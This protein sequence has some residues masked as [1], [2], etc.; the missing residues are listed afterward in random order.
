MSIYYNSEMVR[1]L[2]RERIQEAEAAGLASRVECAAR[3]ARAARPEPRIKA[4]FSRLVERV[5][6]RASSRTSS[7]PS[8]A[9]PAACS[10]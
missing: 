8:N 10:C 2:T 4:A 5:A 7:R 1:L 9:S 6:G 3:E